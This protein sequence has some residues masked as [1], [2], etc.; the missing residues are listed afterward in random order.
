MRTRPAPV[1]VAVLAVLAAA[2]VGALAGCGPADDGPQSKAPPGPSVAERVKVLNADVFVIDGRHTRLADA[3]TPQPI[4]DAR[5]WAE[6]LAAKQATLAT[7]E[8]VRNAGAL[9][10]AP[11]GKTDEYNRQ[12]A[13]VILDNQ[14]L[15]RSLYDMGMAA[16]TSAGRFVWCQPVSAGGEGAPDYKSLMDFGPG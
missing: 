16:Q 13:H 7:R 2:S 10:V 8:L 5:C 15:A 11:T 4:P 3:I 12:I 6:A 14:D 9:R 1:V